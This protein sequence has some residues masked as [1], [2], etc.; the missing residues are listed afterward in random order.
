MRRSLLM[1]VL[2]L[3][4]SV[5]GSSAAGD[6]TTAPDYQSH[7]G[8]YESYFDYIGNYPHFEITPYSEKLQGVT[9]DDNFWYITQILDMWK[10]PVGVYLADPPDPSPTNGIQHVGYDDVAGYEHLGDLDYHQGYLFVPL[11]EKDGYPNGLGVFRASDLAFLGYDEM[12]GDGSWLAVDPRDGSIYKAASWNLSNLLTRIVIDWN[13]LAQNPPVV[14]ILSTQYV[15]LYGLSGQD[16]FIRFSQGA[17]FSES[18]NL[19]YVLTGGSDSSEEDCAIYVFDTNNWKLVSRSYSLDPLF[20]YE[21]HPASTLGDESEGV[22]YWDLDD[23]RAPYIR[24]QLHVQQLYVIG[25]P[26]SDYLYFQHYSGVVYVN[27]ASTADGEDGSYAYPYRQASSAATRAWWG[28]TIKFWPG[29]YAEPL[30]FAAYTNLRPKDGSAVLGPTGN[31]KL[32]P[33]GGIDLAD[34]GVLKIP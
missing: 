7:L 1:I 14:Q 19:L 28:S 11:E 17:D 21:C 8:P 24:G 6:L 31:V 10:Y 9:N 26:A 32:S 20:D 22:T 33:G 27:A 4:V 29:N 23:G 13:K 30:R 2:L 5:G 16:F 12:G 34:I 15:H 3:A 25:G 18:G